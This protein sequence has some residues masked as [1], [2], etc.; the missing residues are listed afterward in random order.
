MSDKLANIKQIASFRFAG[1]PTD[2]DNNA[3]LKQEGLSF[4]ILVVPLQRSESMTL[5]NQRRRCWMWV[6]PGKSL[7]WD[8]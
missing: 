6:T 5:I 8:V 2:N 1:L 7:G 3:E 4:D